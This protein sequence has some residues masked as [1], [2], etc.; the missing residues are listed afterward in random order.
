VEAVALADTQRIAAEA[1]RCR[2]RYRGKQFALLCS[3]VT[4]DLLDKLQD[5]LAIVD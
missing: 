4:R 2:Q 1:L 3:S 5:Q